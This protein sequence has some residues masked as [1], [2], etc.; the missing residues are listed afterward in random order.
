MND[1]SEGNRHPG[2]DHRHLPFAGNAHRLRPASRRVDDDE[3]AGE[4]NRELE[5]PAED[6]GDDD[7]RR[8]NRDARS[9]SALDE[10]QRGAKQ[11]RLLVEALPKILIGGDD[12]QPMENRDEDR[13][14][15]DE[16]ERQTEVVLHEAHP[17][18]VRLT[19]R[20]EERDRAR[21]RRHDGQ[22]DRSPADRLV[23][24]EVMPEVAIAPRSPMAVE[25][26]RDK[27]ADQHD[28][29]D[30]AHAKM[31]LIA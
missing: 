21:L 5:V 6:R 10:E 1:Q 7:R 19:W 9:K 23:A 13:A 2:E 15:D 11:A 8:V 22:P 16:S 28:V 3:N 30:P 25:C 27:R 31:R 20:G 12:F 29:I 17:A 24:F 4:Q 14:D 18:F 26:D